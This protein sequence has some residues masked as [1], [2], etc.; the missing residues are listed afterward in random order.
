MFFPRETEEHVDETDLAD[1][2]EARFH[3]R[4]KLFHADGAA[5]PTLRHHA[6][7]FL[8]NCVAHP[9][10]AVAPGQ[11]SVQFHDLTSAWLNH[12]EKVRPSAI[13]RVTNKG[14]WV[15]HNAVSH[16]AIGLVPCKRTF[17]VHDWTAKLMQVP[18]WV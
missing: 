2:S 7:W 8:H 16:I 17:E 4:V 9:L 5:N 14:L 6:L 18:G 1:T 12:V 3:E 13:P 10:L 15:L 11:K